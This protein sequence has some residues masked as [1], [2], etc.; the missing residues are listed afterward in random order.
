MKTSSVSRTERPT[1]TSNGHSPWLDRVSQEI[2]VHPLRSVAQAAL[3]GMALHHL[4]VRRIL[5]AA[6]R[7][8]IP[9]VFAAGVYHL[10]QQVPE[11]LGNEQD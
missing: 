3:V 2:Q 11:E 8:V 9:G 4:P 10:Y 7:L 1:H 5:G 6:M